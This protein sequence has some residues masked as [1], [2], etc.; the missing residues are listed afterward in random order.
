MWHVIGEQAQIQHTG[1]TGHTLTTPSPVQGLTNAA[2]AS[3][4]TEPRLGRM[5]EHGFKACK[6]VVVV[7]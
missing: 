6:R 2:D 3:T 5:S 4:Q 1:E 7:S